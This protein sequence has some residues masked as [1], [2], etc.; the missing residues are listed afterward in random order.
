M[1]GLPRISIVTPSF[2]QGRFFAATIESVLS[3]EYENLEYIV[4]D[5]GSTDGSIDI[6]QRYAHRLAYRVSE[7]DRGQA[8]AIIRGFQ[9]FSSGEIMGW[10]NS[11]D[12]LLPHCLATVARSFIGFPNDAD[13]LLEYRSHQRARSCAG[14][15]SADPGGIP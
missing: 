3:Q 7:P 2:N 11:D 9:L 14:A 8:D 5:G 12:L 13:N 15:K 1:A 6:I 10:L 4:I